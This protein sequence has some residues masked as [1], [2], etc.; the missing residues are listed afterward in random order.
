M[1]ISHSRRNRKRVEG[2]GIEIFEGEA[3]SWDGLLGGLN[4]TISR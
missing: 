1:D 3:G 4:K 2:V